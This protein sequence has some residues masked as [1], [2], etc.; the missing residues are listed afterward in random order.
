MNPIQWFVEALAAGAAAK[1]K[2][3]PCA[4]RET[5]EHE[6]LERLYD[7]QE[8]FLVAYGWVRGANGYWWTPRGR[9]WPRE[10]RE[11]SHAVNSQL[12]RIQRGRR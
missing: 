2:C 9:G 7:E 3:E 12:W 8:R 5:R 10:A 1:Q 4:S 11:F 6:A